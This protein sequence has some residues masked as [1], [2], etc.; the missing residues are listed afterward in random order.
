MHRLERL[1]QERNSIHYDFMRAIDSAR[2]TNEPDERDERLETAFAECDSAI[3]LLQ[4]TVGST[5]PPSAS[6]IRR[7]PK[8]S[9]R[10]WPR[11]RRQSASRRREQKSESESAT[12]VEKT[13][14]PVANKIF[15]KMSSTSYKRGVRKMSQERRDNDVAILNELI[16]QAQS[17]RDLIEAAK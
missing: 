16:E 8:R 1:L 9:Q 14:Q 6:M 5:M 11:I 12:F 4:N 3:R 2:K 15:K 7:R 10:M 13:L 17:L